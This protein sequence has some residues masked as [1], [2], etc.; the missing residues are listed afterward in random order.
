[1]TGKVVAILGTLDTKGVE[2][3]WLKA[4]VEAAGAATLTIDVGILGAPAFP[5][6]VTAEEVARAAGADLAALRDKGDRGEA[7]A[8]MATGAAE[9]VARLHREGRIDGI[10]SMGG[11]G[12]TA[13]ATAAMRALPVGVPKLMVI[14]A[15]G[16][17]RARLRR[18]QRRDDDAVRRRH[19]RHQPHLRRIIANAAAAM[20]GMVKAEPPALAGRRAAARSPRPCSASPRPASTRRAR[21]ARGGRLRGARLPRHRHRRARR[22]EALIRDGFIAGVL[23]ITTTELAD[24]LVGGV[25]SAGPHRLDGGRRGGRSRRWSRSARSTWS[26]SAR[27]RRSRRSSRDRTFYQHNPQV[28]LMR[29]TAE[30]NAELGTDHRREARPGEGAD[31]ADAA[32]RGR[33]ADRRRGQAVP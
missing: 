5:P 30:E 33:V 31:G 32:A 25:L 14:D 10:V 15:R 21:R 6:D 12:G 7:V 26:I 20:A 29:T 18:R 3:A 17:R 19:R 24:E 4:R 11:G 13:I 2:F 27:R 23:D 28:T 9:V 8:A 22:M 16:G 1:M